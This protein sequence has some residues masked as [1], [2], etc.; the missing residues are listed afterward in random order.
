[1]SERQLLEEEE[2]ATEMAGTVEEILQD[3]FD[4]AS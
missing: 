1:L 4:L 2:G 3:T